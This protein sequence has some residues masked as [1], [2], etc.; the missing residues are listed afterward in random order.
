MMFTVYSFYAMPSRNTL[1]VH[2]LKERKNRPII[3]WG[4][5]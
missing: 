1:L 3:G 2:N 4:D 5:A